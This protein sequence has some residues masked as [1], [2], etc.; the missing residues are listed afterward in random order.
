MTKICLCA[1][2]CHYRYLFAIASRPRYPHLTLVLM[3]SVTNH[4]R[5]TMRYF[6]TS[7]L[8]RITDFNLSSAMLSVYPPVLA[9][10]LLIP[11]LCMAAPHSKGKG[12]I[13]FETR[14]S[15]ALH[16]PHAESRAHRMPLPLAS[17]CGPPTATGAASAPTAA[18]A[19][20]VLSTPTAMAG[21]A[22]DSASS[23]GTVSSLR[24]IPILHEVI[25]KDASMD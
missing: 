22:Q 16:Q 2:P 23:H 13:A 20:T 11:C 1:M 25:L 19:S 7:L 21:A 15:L 9:V 3:A 10:A 5:S 12:D 6:P 17:A 18:S 14:L 4:E 8:T 24:I